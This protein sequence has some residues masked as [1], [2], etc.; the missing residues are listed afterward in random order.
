MRERALAPAAAEPFWSRACCGRCSTQLLGLCLSPNLQVL[1]LVRTVLETTS[2]TRVTQIRATNRRNRGALLVLPLYQTGYRGA[3]VP[4]S[5]SALLQMAEVRQQ[6]TL[7]HHEQAQSWAPSQSALT[8]HGL[9][10]A[11]WLCGVGAD[12]Q[13][14]LPDPDGEEATCTLT[15]HHPLTDLLLLSSLDTK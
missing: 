11:C 9:L 5:F 2:S 1:A 6:P 10:R 12:E 3:R 4:S 7:F 14:P 15:R 8:D 13:W